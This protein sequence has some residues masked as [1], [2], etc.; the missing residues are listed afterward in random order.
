MF[1]VRYDQR[2]RLSTCSTARAFTTFAVPTNGFL[3]DH[4]DPM[5][6]GWALSESVCSSTSIVA[7]GGDT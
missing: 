2:R 6:N 7:I 5:H 4:Y 1:S 3:S